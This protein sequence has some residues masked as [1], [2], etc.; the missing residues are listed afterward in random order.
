MPRTPA[1]F[2]WDTEKRRYYYDSG[3][4]VPLRTLENWIDKASANAELRLENLTKDLISNKI[5]LVEWT[6]KFKD[7]IRNGHNAMAMIAAGGRDQM[8]AKEWG[9]AGNIIKVQYKYLDNFARQIES[10]EISLTDALA[11]RARMYG[12]AMYPSYVSGVRQREINAGATEERSVLTP[13]DGW[14]NGSENGCIEQAARGWV[15]IGDLIP[16]GDRLCM[17]RC[18]CSY[19]SR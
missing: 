14:C 4:A 8:T 7:E 1:K 5:D 6:L 9:K 18:R 15:P 13:A 17:V 3:R 10:G 16:L 12:A 11:V 2:T 19:E